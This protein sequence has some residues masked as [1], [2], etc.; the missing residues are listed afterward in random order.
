MS[1][2][3]NLFKQ[4]KD[5]ILQEV[6]EDLY[7]QIFSEGLRKNDILINKLKEEI[8]DF[9]FEPLIIKLTERSEKHANDFVE[10]QIKYGEDMAK[11]VENELKH[12]KEVEVTA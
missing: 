7:K 9:D 4:Q 2:I 5:K 1:N 6:K 10:L 8:K 11:L 3:I 12:L